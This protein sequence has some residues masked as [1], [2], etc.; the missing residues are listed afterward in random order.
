M[1]GSTKEGGVVPF[2]EETRLSVGED[3]L[4]DLDS[5]EEELKEAETG[6]ERRGKAVVGD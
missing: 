1:E 6:K 4:A 5:E 2:E 3:D